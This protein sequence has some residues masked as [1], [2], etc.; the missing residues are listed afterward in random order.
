LVGCVEF[1]HALLP[2]LVVWKILAHPSVASIYSCIGN[3]G[4]N[5]TFRMLDRH[6]PST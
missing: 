4:A 2:F 3:I 6:L 5:P 1:V